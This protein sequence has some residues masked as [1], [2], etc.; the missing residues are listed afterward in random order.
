MRLTTKYRLA[1]FVCGPLCAVLACAGIAVA[2]ETP[3]LRF[4]KNIGDLRGRSVDNLSVSVVGD[5]SVCLLMRCGRV[6]VFDKRGKYQR[7]LEA[8]LSW[9]QDFIYL[10]AVGKR[11]LL[12]DYQK[13][14]SW[15]YSD[16]RHGS[17][18]GA[19]DNPSM[20]AEDDAGMIYVS[21]TGNRRIQLFAP[22]NTRNPAA[23]LSLSAK[24][25]RIAVKDKNLVVAT[26]DGSVVVYGR[27][28]GSFSPRAS[29]R[30]I[31][32]VRSVCFGPDHSLYVAQTDSLKRYAPEK[33]KESVLQETATLAPSNLELWPNVFEDNVSMVSGPED[34]IF[35]PSPQHGKLLVLDPTK[36]SIRECGSL[37]WRALAVGFAAD[38]TLYTADDAENDGGTRIRTF[39]WNHGQ[40]SLLGTASKNPLYLD[41]NV[42]VW[43]L[44]PD[45]DGGV[46]IRVLEEGYQKGW[47]AL[48]IKKVFANGQIKPFLDFGE[49]YAKRTTFHPSA[50]YYSMKFDSSRNIILA[51]MPLVAV[52]NVTRDGRILWEAGRQ[53]QGGAEKIEFGMPRDVAVDRR[54]NIWVSD[55]AKDNILCLSPHGKLLSTYGHHAGVDDVDGKGFDHPSGIQIAK[56]GGGEYLYVGDSGNRR[57]VK[58]RISQ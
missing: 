21:D 10:S 1:R 57:I 28:D 44:L 30:G 18:P 20:V 53:P 23:I 3:T 56:C 29:Q 47:P 55:F 16:R 41:R 11:L 12:G 35:F 5:G 25:G 32:G 51:A 48:T 13:D 39:K 40:L 49:L 9:P 14:F 43:G 8:T 34:A 50:A 27:K 19:F 7:S 24:P 26:E 31:A 33:G 6:A 4:D 52:Y 15:V 2:V 42:P 58:F 37:P 22:D 36:D 17:Q 45:N 38:A 46:Y 54:G